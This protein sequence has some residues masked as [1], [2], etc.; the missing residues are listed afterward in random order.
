MSKA[1]I[2]FVVIVMVFAASTAV[3]A[4]ESSGI[5]RIGFLGQGKNS[6][7]KGK[8]PLAFRTRLRELGWV[9]GENIVI[10]WRFAKGVEERVPLFIND[11]VRHKVD[12]MVLSSGHPVHIAKRATQTIPI[13]TTEV[14]YPVESGLINS[15]ARPGRNIT[16]LTAFRH[17]LDGKRIEILKEVIP[18]L[19]QVAILWQ[20]NREGV[21]RALKATAIAAQ[22][23][24]VR[25][26][27]LGVQKVADL[28]SAVA[29]I[30]DKRTTGLIAMHTQLIHSY[31]REIVGMVNQERI[32]AI[33]QD[34]RYAVD[35]GL[36][37]YGPDTPAIYARA[38]TYVDKI[39]RGAKP[40]F[41]PVERP[42]KFD[43]VVN[44]KTAGQMG[45]EI[46]LGVLKWANEVIQ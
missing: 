15:L 19:S 23:L 13:I 43:L 44:L 18:G 9:E 30:S 26:K 2:L 5:P 38:A 36:L 1:A 3:V 14:N 40:A 34:R 7:I 37:S 6:H 4:Q 21:Q 28:S 29:S 24:G 33:Y 39:L 35:G 10:E 16:G 17:Q 20:S 12:A 31:R 22:K 25:L 41:L 8:G 11:F 27:L 46:P 45:I 42:R 32:P